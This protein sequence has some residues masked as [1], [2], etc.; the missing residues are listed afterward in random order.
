MLGRPFGIMLLAAALLTAGL[1]GIAALLSAWPRT[2]NTSPLAALFAAVWSC[3]YI[4]AGVLTW[5]RSRF[6]PTAFI[7]A[8]GL[9]M[10]PMSRLFPGGGVL[11][12]LLSSAV[13]LSFILL[14][15]RYL[16]RKC[17]PAW[18]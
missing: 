16:R 7:A 12:L 10:F 3:A 18:E 2:A 6:A 14:G 15:Y 4:V 13:I 1:A 11:F 9:L 5:R 17:E 8:I